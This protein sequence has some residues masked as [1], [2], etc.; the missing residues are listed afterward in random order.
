[1]RFRI[2]FKW[3]ALSAILTALLVAPAL[4]QGKG[5]AVEKFKEQRIEL[6]KQLKLAP[7]KEKAVLAVGDKYN[8]QRKEIIAGLKKTHDEL[9]TA[10][11]APTPDEAK[12]KDL[13]AS[14][15][16]GQDK[17][18]DTFRSQRNEEQSLMTPIEQGK[19]LLALGKWRKEMHSGV[20]EKA[21]KG[22]K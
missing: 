3:L 12:V 20:K 7:D 14:L 10:L 19:Y 5:E 21:P 6:I 1:M 17:L 16:A 9:Q 11:A 22:K 15:N 18:F 4:A 8:A 13:V 2:N